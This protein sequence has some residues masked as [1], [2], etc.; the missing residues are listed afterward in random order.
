VVSAGLVRAISSSSVGRILLEAQI[1]PHRVKM[2]CHSNDLWAQC[3]APHRTLGEDPVLR[4]HEANGRSDDHIYAPLAVILLDQR[5]LT[6]TFGLF[7]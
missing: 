2:W 6:G 3:E 7:H 1:K 5:A 4:K